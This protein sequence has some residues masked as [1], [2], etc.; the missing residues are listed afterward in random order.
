V[1]AVKLH[2]MSDIHLDHYSDRGASLLRDLDPEDATVVVVAGDVADGRFPDQYHT[3][4]KRLRELYEH[5]IIVTG[6][7]DYYKSTPALTHNSLKVAAEN[8]TN[9]HFLNKSSVTID[10]KT[11][12]GATMWFRDDPLN[13]LYE[14]WINDFRLIGKEHNDSSLA[15]GPWMYEEQGL[16]EHYIEGNCHEGDIVVTHHLPSKR[17]V[18]PLYKTSELNRFFVCE[19][20]DFIKKRKPALWLHGHTHKACDYRLGKTR[21]VCNPRGYPR[22]NASYKPKL[23][24]VP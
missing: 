2:L 10:G 21:V 8:L 7:H 5:A 13:Q 19:M 14:G 15:P 3:L 12:H 1:V 23:I 6:N 20:D 16:F 11:I 9:I 17:S 22:E 18:D 24:E 4:F